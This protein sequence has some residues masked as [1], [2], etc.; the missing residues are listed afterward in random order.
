M[1]YDVIMCD[2]AHAQGH[3]EFKKG[4]RVPEFWFENYCQLMCSEGQVLLLLTLALSY[5]PSHSEVLIIFTGEDQE[6]KGA[7]K[8]L[9]QTSPS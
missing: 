9:V 7:L 6:I 3:L 1:R 4:Q 5:P 8:H 2:N